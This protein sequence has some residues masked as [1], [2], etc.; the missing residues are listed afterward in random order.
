[1]ASFHQITAERDLMLAER[2]SLA[3]ESVGT[4][5]P[6]QVASAKAKVVAATRKLTETREALD[7]ARAALSVITEQYSP[8][9]PIYPARST[10]R[11]S[12]LAWW[13]AN[14]HNPLTAR[15][16]VNHIWARHF[17]RPLVDSVHDFGHNGKRPSHPELLDWLAVEFMD[18]EWRMKP[19]HRTLVTSRAYC[20][21]SHLSESAHPNLAVD[22]DN[23]MLWRFNARR[24]EAEVVRDSLLATSGELDCSIGGQEIEI[25][26]WSGSKRRSLYFSSHGEAK[27]PFID[28]FDGPNV[29]DCYVRTSSVRPQQALAL[30][31][32]DVAWHQARV[33]AG[34]MWQAVD[35]PTLA[36]TARAA[37]FVEASF[38]QVLTRGPREAERSLAVE[39]LAAQ[40]EF[41]SQAIAAGEPLSAPP[42]GIIPPATDVAQRARE[43]FVHALYNHHD[44]VTLR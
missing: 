26:Q 5:D 18:H 24:L 21:Q 14:R 35:Q 36:P 20:T 12:A 31:N 1:L 15:V 40:S 9:S 42:P 16:A 17:G 23:R 3:V 27:V 7:A 32:S 34:R 4:P 30:S 2:L 22:P 43:D 13:I 38:E 19:L 11:R 37:L 29:C 6:P 28:L 8:L 10:G 41:L 39:F 33:L 44:F 25:E